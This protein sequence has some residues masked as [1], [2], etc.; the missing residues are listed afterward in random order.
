MKETLM[1]VVP[2][3]FTAVIMIQLVLAGRKR[4]ACWI[5]AAV[6]QTVASGYNVITDQWGYLP[7][8]AYT[9]IMAVYYY[10]QWRQE[11]RAAAK[12]AKVVATCT[13]GTAA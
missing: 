3:I 11:E 4:A 2:W 7:M 8:N 5:V 1:A 9:V 10:R 6:V 12:P 13:C